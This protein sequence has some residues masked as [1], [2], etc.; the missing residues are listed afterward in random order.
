MKRVL[1]TFTLGIISIFVIVFVFVFYNKL[2][3]P[4]LPIEN[5]SKK[6]VVEKINDSN[7]QM[8]K[9]TNE[10]DKVWY[11]IKERDGSVADAMIVEMLNQYDWVF[12]EKDGA[13]LFFEKNGET[14]IITK[15]QWTGD[16]KLVD[17][18]IHFGE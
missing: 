16:Y 15:K 6:E 11:L 4:P 7:T 1:V 2:Y 3:Y 10:N 17:I 5:M 8:I 13:G 14:L 12:K 18:P 9:S